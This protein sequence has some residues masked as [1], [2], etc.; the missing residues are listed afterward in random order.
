MIQEKARVP[1]LS[2]SGTANSGNHGKLAFNAD[3]AAIAI[4][5]LLAVLVRFGVLHGVGW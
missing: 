2:T 4:A 3:A 1:R 5:L